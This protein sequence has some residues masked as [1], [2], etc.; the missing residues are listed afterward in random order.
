MPQRTKPDDDD[1]A[2]FRE[3]MTDVAPLRVKQRAAYRRRPAPLPT[4][5]RAD[6]AA[7]LQE[8]L[9]GDWDPAEFETGEELAYR[10]PGIQHALL[11]KLRRGLI[12]AEAE[13]DLH[14][15]TTAAAH[16]AVSRFLDESSALG[17]RCVRVIHGKGLGSGPH[18]PVLKRKLDVWLRRRRGVLAFCSARPADGG[19]GAALVLIKRPR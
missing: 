9:E 4:H 2:L 6:E 12:R 3:K 17:L 15:M 5:T 10:Q 19:T 7:A 18:G 11:R 16:A 14:G 8:S 1:T 13:L